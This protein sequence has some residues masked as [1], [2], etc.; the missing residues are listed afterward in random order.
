[1]SSLVMAGLARSS[2]SRT[3]TLTRSWT[4]QAVRPGIPGVDGRRAGSISPAVFARWCCQHSRCRFSSSVRPP[5]SGSSWQYSSMWSAS[6]AQEV[7]RVQPGTAQ[8]ELRSRR[9]SSI[10][11]VGA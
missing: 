9:C 6:E 2:L 4:D 3:I 10:A 1:M 11:R 8:V 5:C 7:E